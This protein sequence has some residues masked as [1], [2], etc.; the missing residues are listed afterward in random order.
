VSQSQKIRVPN[1]Y[2][3]IS[4][5]IA[6]TAVL[7]WFIPGGSFE[8]TTLNGREIIVQD[9]FRFVPANGQGIGAVLM[10]PIRGFIDAARIIGF[11]LIVGGVFAILQKTNAIT[12]VITRLIAL[13]NRFKSMRFLIIP[14]IMTLFSLGGATF[15]MSEEVIPFVLILIPLAIGMGYDTITALAMTYLAAHVGFSAAFLNPFTIGVAQGIAGLQPFS[16]LEY[17]LIVWLVMT[18]IAI[19]F[20]VRYAG[21]I[22]RHPERSLTFA[23][24]KEIRQS[25]MDHLKEATAPKATGRIYG[26]LAVFVAGMSI[27]VFG[28]LYLQWYIDEITAVFVGIGIAAGAVARL[29]VNDVTNAFLQGARDLV[30]TALI[31]ALARG[32]LVVAQ[33]G[34]IIATMLH[35][36]ATAVADLGPVVSA[37]MMFVI[38]SAI[39][40]FVPSG[41]G[42]AA[43]TMPIMAPLSDLLG[44]SRQTAVLAFQFGD[45]LS[46]MVIPTSAVLMSSLTLAKVSWD[47]WI[48]WIWP[49]M[50]ILFATAIL[51]L[52]PPFYLSWQ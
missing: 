3:L 10:A 33:D 24:D 49:L 21:K 32:I 52:I 42:Q 30:A 28:V 20:V 12:V 14:F 23:K 29:S 34:N 48:K 44:V 17:R 6:I 38:Q 1:T 7:T 19:I 4:L 25:V 45:G 16:G 15:G 51:L 39:N 5:I 18:S 41:S 9:S 22:S 31:I 50:L 47:K 11:V 35:Y 40:F 36:T 13:Q 26:V 27:M 43:L 2:F 37:Q 8:T 46:N